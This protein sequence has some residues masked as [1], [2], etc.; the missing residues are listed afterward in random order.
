MAARIL[1]RKGSIWTYYQAAASSGNGNADY[2]NNTVDQHLHESHNH[3]NN[4]D[5]HTDGAGGEHYSAAS[6]GRC[7]QHS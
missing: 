5:Q 7:V 6:A 4:V 3:N 2:P 1:C